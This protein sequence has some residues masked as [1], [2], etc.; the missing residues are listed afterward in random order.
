MHPA[1]QLRQLRRLVEA[2]WARTSAVEEEW[3]DQ[4]D[5]LRDLELALMERSEDVAQQ[6]EAVDREVDNLRRQTLVFGARMK[7]GG[8]AIAGE[9]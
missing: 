5:R 9:L 2:L 7:A 3:S 8:K 1:L 4:R 6:M